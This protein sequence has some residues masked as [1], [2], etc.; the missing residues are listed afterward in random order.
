MQELKEIKENKIFQIKVIKNMIF[1]YLEQ[2]TLYE[3]HKRVMSELEKL[4]LFKI[5]MIK[6]IKILK[7]I[8]EKFIPL[9]KLKKIIFDYKNNN[10]SDEFFEFI[11]LFAIKCRL[12]SLRSKQYNQTIND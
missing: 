9:I 10:N 1:Y 8:D 7:N 11:G 5:K 12:N 4:Y 6:N 2:L 3:R